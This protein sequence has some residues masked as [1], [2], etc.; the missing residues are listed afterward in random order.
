MPNLTLDLASK[1]CT[2]CHGDMPALKGEELAKLAIQVPGW[3]VVNEHHIEKTYQFP[4]F[5][6][7]LA[8][9]NKVGA[10]AEEQAHHPD[11]YLA[12]GK[13]GIKTYT[14][15]IDGLTENDFILAAKCD[16]LL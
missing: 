16:Q 7:G 9:V 13:V 2:A 15:A 5:A 6:Q 3:K 8:F 12:W 10:M 4:D 14:H 11:I 1:K